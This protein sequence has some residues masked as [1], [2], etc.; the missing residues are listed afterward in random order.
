M[1]YSFTFGY[2]YINVCVQ[3]FA[4]DD[5]TYCERDKELTFKGSCAANIIQSLTY[6]EE[7]GAFQKIKNPTSLASE[8]DSLKQFEAQLS[9]QVQ[10][11]FQVELGFQLYSYIRSY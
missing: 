10:L 8:E 11:Q 1:S 2:I 9:L 7:S 6:I 5:T 3:C 4:E